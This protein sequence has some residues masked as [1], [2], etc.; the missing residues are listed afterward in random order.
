MT[1]LQG[2]S[3]AGG[4]TPFANPKKIYVLRDQGGKQI[5]LPFNYNAVVKG[6]AQE[7]NV[8]LMAGDTIVVP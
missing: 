3:D 2:L 7:Q 6:K 4:F 8:P 5:K 1:V